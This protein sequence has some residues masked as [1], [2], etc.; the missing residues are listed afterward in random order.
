MYVREKKE[1]RKSNQK[2][3]R[4]KREKKAAQLDKA[5]LIHVQHTH[6]TIFLTNSLIREP[7]SLFLNFVPR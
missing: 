5:I 7:N 3:K 6:W 4:K 1:K 2:E